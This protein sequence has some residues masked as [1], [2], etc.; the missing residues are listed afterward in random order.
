MVLTC[1]C[2]C[3]PTIHDQNFQKKNN[4]K[5]TQDAGQPVNRLGREQLRRVQ[6]R[7]ATGAHQISGAMISG[8]PGGG[9]NKAVEIKWPAVAAVEINWAAVALIWSAVATSSVISRAPRCC[10]L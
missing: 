4:N 3:S 1:R 9:K 8:T 6:P 5:G 2:L 10:D 7:G